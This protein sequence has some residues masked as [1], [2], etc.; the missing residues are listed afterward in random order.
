MVH[1]FTGH[2]PQGDSGPSGSFSISA[3]ISAI[4]SR[5]W[6]SSSSGVHAS[7][8]SRSG[9]RSKGVK[10]RD[11]VVHGSEFKPTQAVAVRIPWR[12]EDERDAARRRILAQLL[13]DPP[14]VE[15]GHHHVEKDHIR[16]LA[17]CG[18]D[19]L[20]ALLLKV[21]AIHQPERSLIVDYENL[22]RDCTRSR[23]TFPAW[24]N[25]LRKSP[26]S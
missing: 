16:R 19:D 13:G 24:R 6:S 9:A 26:P 17:Q 11:D 5:L 15:S 20:H 4:F 7:R 21:D 14:A 18:L 1:A 10:R 8:S 3:F 25:A 22:G 23:G 2:E 12:H